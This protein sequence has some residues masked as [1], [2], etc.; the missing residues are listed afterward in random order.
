M[1]E[2]DGEVPKEGRKEETKHRART[3]SRDN[4]AQGSRAVEGRGGGDRGRSRNRDRSRSKTSRRGSRDKDR[5]SQNETDRQKAQTKVSKTGKK[6]GGS[7]SEGSTI[8]T[9]ATAIARSLMGVTEGPQQKT[10][11]V[12]VKKEKAMEDRRYSGLKDQEETTNNEGELRKENEKATEK[13]INKGNSDKEEKPQRTEGTPV[14]DQAKTTR[15]DHSKERREKNRKNSKS[16]DKT[17]PTQTKKRNQDNTNGGEK[18]Q[19][20]E[21]RVDK[22]EDT[23]RNKD[24]SNGNDTDN[25]NNNKINDNNNNKH[26]NREEKTEENKRNSTPGKRKKENKRDDN[27]NERSKSS[28]KEKK[29]PRQQQIL[30]TPKRI[31]MERGGTKPIDINEEE[32]D[33]PREKKSDKDKAHQ[34]ENAMNETT[35]RKE[36]ERED[37]ANKSSKGKEGKEATKHGPPRILR[38]N[39]T[40]KQKETT[41]TRNEREETNRT[42]TNKTNTKPTEAK[43]TDTNTKEQTEAPT[44][45]SSNQKQT[46]SYAVA[47]NGGQAL[48]RTQEKKRGK[49]NRRF[50]VSFT[51]EETANHNPESELLN[52]RNTL[53]AILKRAKH[54]DKNSMI[55]T[56]R[57]SS[58]MRTIE[59]VED[60][61]FTPNDFKMYLNHPYK[62]RKVLRRNSGWR[63]NLSFSIPHE[64]FL[65]YWELSKREYREVPYVTLKDAPMQSE[66]Y[67]NCGTFLN[68]SDGQLTSQLVE[69]LTKEIGT[70]IQCSFR[71][72]PLDKI[73]AD[74]FWKHAYNKAKE[75]KGSVFKYAPLAL[76]VYA[77]SAELARTVA[78][79][80]LEKYGN[81]D[82]GQY[83]RM[84]DGS[85]MRFIPAGRF[86]D[87][88]GRDTAK[89]LFVN[90]I[91]FNSGQVKMN[92]PIQQINKKFP[93]HDN[94]SMMELILDMQCETKQNEP[95]FRHIV[96]MWTRDF[97][98]VKYQVSI[99]KEMYEEARKMIVN[100]E[101]E[102]RKRYGDEVA[103]EVTTQYDDEEGTAL[104]S[105]P[106]YSMSTL[107]LD[108]N[109]RYLNGSARFIIEGME[110]MT[111]NENTPT[112]AAQK[113]QEEDNYTMEMASKGTNDTN[114][115]VA[116][117]KGME[118]EGNTEK[119]R[120]QKQREQNTTEHT[121]TTSTT[122]LS[123]E[124]KKTENWNRIG[125]AEA[126]ERLKTKLTKHNQTHDPG[127]KERASN[128]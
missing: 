26:N 87:M 70:K 45:T 103:A 106:S 2:S 128:P 125:S 48:L 8:F 34:E 82:K 43:E 36:Q 77:E 100:M 69:G 27:N 86:L 50:E 41:P 11:T 10:M 47:A 55:N 105:R 83:P 102:L 30:F 58:H 95:Y 107:T 52:I 9:T 60:F 40:Q 116:T 81:Q 38:I 53:T 93:Q 14:K 63:I 65:H 76:N 127:G 18:D 89:S 75:G 25:N 79:R 67:Y 126:E 35:E 44:P 108:T 109:D 98:E 56:W 124:G 112:L 17:K 7:S 85:R 122:S 115:T 66:R 114:E 71:P 13:D 1:A 33:Y 23:D 12:E 119:T 120:Y 113:A 24:N 121:T 32:P 57:E 72:A 29:K 64:L 68:S 123:R 84:P 54:V 73:A 42:T 88:A 19:D 99:H 111:A 97:K 61:P 59:K 22:E 6:Q 46:I 39:T 51:I 101:E 37:T 49:N 20:K 16:K 78:K 5:S 90:Q 74:T 92:L 110:N 96:K 21:S 3:M 28:G 31:L 117:M 91:Q 62:D 104:G 80:L 4:R 94:K 15:N 118:D